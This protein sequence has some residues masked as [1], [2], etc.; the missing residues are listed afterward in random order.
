PPVEN[1]GFRGHG[2]SELQLLPQ[3][4]FASAPERGRSG[5]DRTCRVGAL[6][7]LGGAP[8]QSEISRS[9]SRTEHAHSA[10]SSIVSKGVREPR[11]GNDQLSEGAQPR[12]AARL[13]RRVSDSPVAGRVQ[14]NQPRWLH[15]S[16]WR[17]RQGPDRFLFHSNVQSAIEEFLYSRRD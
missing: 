9:R 2:R 7:R 16:A 8:A 5:N 15:E 10:R 13:S 17:L 12:N 4:R 14:A 3:E 11:G 1:G 6:P